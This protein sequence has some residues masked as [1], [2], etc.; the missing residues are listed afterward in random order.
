MLI[1]FYLYSKRKERK[2]KKRKEKKR[3][4]KKRKEKKRKEKGKKGRGKKSEMINISS[5]FLFAI[6][7]RFG[8]KQDH[9][10]GRFKGIKNWKQEGLHSIL[11]QKEPPIQQDE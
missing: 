1:V 7:S 11:F 2:A 6:V 4:E 9:I 8:S 3:K 10:P 5:S